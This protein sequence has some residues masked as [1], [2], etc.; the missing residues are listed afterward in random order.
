MHHTSKFRFVVHLGRVEGVPRGDF[1]MGQAT[2]VG[3]EHQSDT[4]VA[5]R[6]AE[7]AFT[8]LLNRHHPELFGFLVRQT[9]DPELAAD[10]TQETALAAFRNFNQLTDPG[11]FRAWLYGIARN[12]LRMEWRRRL[13]QTVSLDALLA[14][15][16]AIPLTARQHDDHAAWHDRE[17]ILPVLDAMQPAH[18]E[19]LL[20]RCMWGFTGDEVARIVDITPAAARKR[21]TRGTHEFRQL[22]RRIAA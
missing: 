18:C 3:K 2:S 19:A 17:L 8:M 16:S 20:L 22:Y 21:I 10:L 1:I 12:Q 14:E 15:P 5:R 6:A 9:A 11:C 7:V 13:H 4:I